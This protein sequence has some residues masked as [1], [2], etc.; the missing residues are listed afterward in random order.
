MSLCLL[1]SKELIDKTEQLVIIS[2]KGHL[3]ISQL[4]P[5]EQHNT[6]EGCGNKGS[7]GSGA[8]RRFKWI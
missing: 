1:G 6:C 2:G 3:W 5:L 7:D 4:P 8:H